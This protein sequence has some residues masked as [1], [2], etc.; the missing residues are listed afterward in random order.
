[1]PSKDKPH[2]QFTLDVSIFHTPQFGHTIAAAVLT[3][4]GGW[5]TVGTW[6]WHGRGV[7]EPL[8]ADLIARVCAV[9]TEHLVTRYGVQGEL[10]FE[11]V[12]DPDPF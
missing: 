8:Y 10:P 2:P 12:G 4:R 9:L 3:K 1:M 7:P 6:S 11:P 5:T